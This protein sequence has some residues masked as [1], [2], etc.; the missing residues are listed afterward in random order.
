VNLE[1]PMALTQGPEKNDIHHVSN[2]SAWRSWHSTVVECYEPTE[3]METRAMI[4][5]LVI[6]VAVALSSFPPSMLAL[7]II[8]HQS[9]LIEH[10]V[11]N[12]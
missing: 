9:Y 10:F 1:L 11:P 5:F 4:V 2:S 7:A 12:P 6:L 8:T 3:S